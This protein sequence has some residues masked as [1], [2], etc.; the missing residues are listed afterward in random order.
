MLYCLR[1]SVVYSQIF[2][3]VILSFLCNLLPFFL[4]DP[5]PPAYF[6]SLF[7][8]SSLRSLSLS[9]LLFF[10]CSCPFLFLSFPCPLSLLPISFIFLHLFSSFVFF[11]H[12]FLTL[13][14]PLSSYLFLTTCTHSHTH[15]PSSFPLTPS[16][17]MKSSFC[18]SFRFFHPPIQPHP[19]HAPP[20]PFLRLY[21]RSTLFTSLLQSFTPT[22]SP[23]LHSKDI[24]SFTLTHLYISS[25]TP[26]AYT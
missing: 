23:E 24:S 19:T 25:P 3:T 22:H 20:S 11:G 4:F 12:Y 26:Y 2:H 1:L 14:I 17:L 15:I 18:P 16:V 5:L 9:L 7:F 8:P 21:T 10:P 6:L 13:D